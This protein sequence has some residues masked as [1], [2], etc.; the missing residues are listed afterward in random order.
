MHQRVMGGCV[1]ALADWV[2]HDWL[3]SNWLLSYSF[4]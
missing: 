3:P 4:L 2:F 1:S